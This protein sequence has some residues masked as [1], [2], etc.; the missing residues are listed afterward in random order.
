MGAWATAEEI[1]SPP[2]RQRRHKPSRKIVTGVTAATIK[3]R[4]ARWRADAA[5][6]YKNITIELDDAVLVAA[7]D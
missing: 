6:T 7:G 1:E 2:E 4:V 3:G 5:G